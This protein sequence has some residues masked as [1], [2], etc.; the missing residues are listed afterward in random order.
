MVAKMREKQKDFTKYGFLLDRDVSKAA[1]LFPKKRTK[2]IA[3]IGL[4]DNASDLKITREAWKRKLTIVTGNGE[5]FVKEIRKFLGQTKR[6]ECHELYGLIVL[7]NGYERQKQVLP[8]IESR[9]LLGREKITW[10]DIAYRNC[11]VRVKGGG[12]VEVKRF[13]RCLYC[14]KNELKWGP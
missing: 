13:P 1:S 11:Y 14:Q 9:L 6:A 12:G 7:P 5:D 3:D 10:T 4:L 2:T 8:G